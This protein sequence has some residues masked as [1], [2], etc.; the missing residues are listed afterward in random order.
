MSVQSSSCG[1]LSETSFT[2]KSQQATS[3]LLSIHYNEEKLLELSTKD[4][5]I[6]GKM[7]KYPIELFTKSSDSLDGLMQMCSVTDIDGIQIY[8]RYSHI[9][10]SFKH[11]LGIQIIL[12]DWYSS[13]YY[14]MV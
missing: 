7:V 2:V 12:Y 6:N 11:K 5:S 9:C 10:S 3:S 4:K 14:N 1:L 13:K 8:A